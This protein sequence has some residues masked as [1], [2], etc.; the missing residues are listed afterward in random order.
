MQSTFKG[1]FRE[2]EAWKQARIFKQQIIEDC[3]CFP[4][5]EKY[6]LISQ[7]KDSSRS[8]TANIAEGYGRFNFQETSQFFRQSRGSLNESLD[9][10][11]TAYDEGYI[12]IETLSNREIQYQ[13][14]LKLI[15]GYI[16][17]LQNSKSKELKNYQNTSHKSPNPN[18]KIP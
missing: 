12:S 18:T 16:L 6:L 11:L 10:I 17:F 8:V 1:G 7:L 3:K 4:K 14:V 5:E 2:L 13:I 9:H 15:N